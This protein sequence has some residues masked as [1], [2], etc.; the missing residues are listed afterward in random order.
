LRTEGLVDKIKDKYQEFK[1]QSYN[2][3]SIAQKSVVLSNKYD[4]YSLHLQWNYHLW[5]RQYI[6]NIHSLNSLQALGDFTHINR[7]LYY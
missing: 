6:D 7:K 4:E 3:D 5:M 1:S 2:I